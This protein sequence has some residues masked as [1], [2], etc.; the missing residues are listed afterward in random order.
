MVS[1]VSP[2]DV[3]SFALDL[4]F[5]RNAEQSSAPSNAAPVL[6]PTTSERVV[7]GYLFKTAQQ[8]RRVQMKYFYRR[9]YEL[10]V[11]REE[12]RVYE[13]EGGAFKDLISC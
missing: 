8:I 7:K 5:L 13:K 9:Y 1:N 4:A 12:L 3:P 11:F 2:G 6:D 10:D